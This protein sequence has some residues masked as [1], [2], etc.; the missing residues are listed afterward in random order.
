MALPRHTAGKENKQYPRK[1]VRP[2]DNQMYV[3]SDPP[4][5]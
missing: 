3:T 4:L 2:R 1:R 5:T